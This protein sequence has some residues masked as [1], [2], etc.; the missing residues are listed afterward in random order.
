MGPAGGIDGPLV[1]QTLPGGLSY[2]PPGR[3]ASMLP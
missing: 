3:V 2:L 1:T